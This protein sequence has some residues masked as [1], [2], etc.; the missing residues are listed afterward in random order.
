MKVSPSSRSPCGCLSDIKPTSEP[1]GL[2]S[3]LCVCGLLLRV[4]EGV[5]WS[6][7]QGCEMKGCVSKSKRLFHRCSILLQLSFSCFGWCCRDAEGDMLLLPS[8]PL[9][10]DVFSTTP[11]VGNTLLFRKSSFLLCL[12]FV[13]LILAVIWQWD[14]LCIQLKQHHFSY[15]CPPEC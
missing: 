14:I 5:N 2:R 8:K 15:I 7:P 4:N 6:R 12:C 1:L 13:F 11:C 10:Q 9:L 3:S